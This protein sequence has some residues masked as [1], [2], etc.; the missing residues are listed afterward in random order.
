MRPNYVRR[1]ALLC[2]AALHTGRDVRPIAV[3][4]AAA[5]RYKAVLRTAEAIKAAAEAASLFLGYA[6]C[7][8]LWLAVLLLVSALRSRQY[9]R[10]QRA[11]RPVKPPVVV[12]TVTAQPTVPIVEG[13]KDLTQAQADADHTGC[14]REEHELARWEDDGG[15]VPAEVDAVPALAQ[16]AADPEPKAT[17]SPQCNLYV[18]SPRKDSRRKGVSYT[19]KPWNGKPLKEGQHLAVKDGK[20]YRRARADE[21]AAAAA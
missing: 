3:A 19:H 20:K 5:G 7:V 21:L 8:V 14:W 9:R 4:L 1:L 17:A 12:P 11:F 2:L 10:R 6:L 18:A 13:E 15:A 16:A